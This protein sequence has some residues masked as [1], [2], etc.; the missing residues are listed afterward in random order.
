MPS[1]MSKVFGRKKE[2]AKEKPLMSRNSHQSLLEGKFEDVRRTPSPIVTTGESSP[3]EGSFGLFRTKSRSAV[4]SP[5]SPVPRLAELPTLSLNLPGQ[6]EENN[7][8]SLGVVFEGDRD[9]VLDDSVIGLKRL[10]PAETITLVKACSQVITERGMLLLCKSFVCWTNGLQGLE[11]LGIM[12]PHWHSASPEN[13]RRLISLFIRSLSPQKSTST[14]FE[15]ELKFTRSPHDVAAVLR[16]GLR[17]LQLDGTS[18][19]KEPA[20]WAWYQT[21]SKEER[22]AEYPPKA[23]TTKLM[24]L[25]PKPH[26]DLLMA[27]LEIESSLAAHAEHNSISGS[28]MSKFL[29][30]WLLTASRA[31]ADDDWES[32]YARWERAGRI[33]EHLF[34]A[35]IRFVNVISFQNG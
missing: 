25:L 26:L 8:R 5:T 11:T 4:K 7:S 33:L 1:F 32:F 20:E 21:F 34:L 22:A 19:G 6:R 12:H 3:R 16:W 13:Q 14:P 2:D 28:K 29:G 17:H 35:R 18:F 27:T 30:L 10:N 24:P 31:E 15:T 9:V 23:F